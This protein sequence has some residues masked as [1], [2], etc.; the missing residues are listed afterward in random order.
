MAGP[1]L[2]IV[3]SEGLAALKLLLQAPSCKPGLAELAV[4]ISQMNLNG[5]RRIHMLLPEHVS[6]AFVGRGLPAV[7]PFSL[8]LL[9]LGLPPPWRPW[10]AVYSVFAPVNIQPV[11]L[12]YKVTVH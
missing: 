5:L 9:T 10:S 12:P 1:I 4:D 6:P 8:C 7:V 11:S 2:E 3:M